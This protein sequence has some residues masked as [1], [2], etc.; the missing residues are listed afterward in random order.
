MT[1]EDL[2]KEFDRLIEAHYNEEIDSR[3]EWLN[4]KDLIEEAAYAA[5]NRAVEL[6]EREI[7]YLKDDVVKKLTI[8]VVSKCYTE[9]DMEGAY[10]KG[11]NEFYRQFPRTEQHAFRDEAKAND[12]VSKIKQGL[13]LPI[14]SVSKR[15]F[16]GAEFDGIECD[17]CGFDAS[18]VDIY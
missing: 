7:I 4:V 5:F 12:I 6:G 16:C 17:R 13:T 15:C 10:D 1:K 18:E 3:D 2:V 11:F 9:K 8:P 14:D